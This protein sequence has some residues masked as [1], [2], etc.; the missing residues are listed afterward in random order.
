MLNKKV[1]IKTTVE[2]IDTFY[3]NCY[4]HQ[5]LQNARFVNNGHKFL[6]SLGTFIGRPNPYCTWS[7]SDH[8]FK[9]HVPQLYIQ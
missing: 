8:F 9:K 5:I 2:S 7:V 3:I 1:S 4:V 6:K